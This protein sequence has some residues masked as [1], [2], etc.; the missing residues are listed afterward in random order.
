MCNRV[1]N[2][3]TRRNMGNKR[4]CHITVGDAGTNGG[5]D[6]RKNTGGGGGLNSGD[7]VTAGEDASAGAGLDAGAGRPL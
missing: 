7:P 2:M 4:V 6:T 5:A 1:N 3:V